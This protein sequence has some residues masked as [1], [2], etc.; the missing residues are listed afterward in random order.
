MC[1]IFQKRATELSHPRHVQYVK[2]VAKLAK[3]LRRLIQYLTVLTDNVTKPTKCGFKD[4]GFGP[5][6]GV[7]DDQNAPPGFIF[8]LNGTSPAGAYDELVHTVWPVMTVIMPPANNSRVSSIPSAYAQMSC[9]RAKTIR[10]GSR[11]PTPLP[12]PTAVNFPNSL[13][14]GAIAGIVVG[15]IIAMA[16]AVAAAFW[17]W[18]R[19]KPA[20][21]K[22]DDDV[23][24]VKNP[25]EPGEAPCYP[26]AEVPSRSWYPV[27]M[28]TKRDSIYQLDTK[29]TPIPE[30]LD[31][32][33][34]SDLGKDPRHALYG[35]RVPPQELPGS[36]PIHQ[37]PATA[38]ASPVTY[39][40]ESGS[41][42]STFVSSISPLSPGSQ[43]QF[44][45][46]LGSLQ[47]G[48]A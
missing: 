16:I 28:D 18:R 10:S 33:S 1:S 32:R 26:P 46:I 12:A 27:E 17:F 23:N 40:D 13:S 3:Y 9:I 30:Q 35:D 25:Q 22:V 43:P 24:L 45:H 19:R 11:K 14:K 38:G 42:A 20:P 47:K 6:T 44:E 15:A 37:Q 5:S 31:D 39:S 7:V 41:T 21:P 4:G 8:K 2:T 29:S 48:Y 34:R 36:T